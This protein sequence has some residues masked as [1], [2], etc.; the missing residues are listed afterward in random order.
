[1][2]HKKNSNIRLAIIILVLV[3]LMS[4]IVSAATVE[5]TTGKLPVQLHEGDQVDLTI[6]IKD[7]E[8][9]K[10]LVIETSLVS[11]NN[12][13]IYDFG[14]YNPSIA[15]NRFNQKITL[16]ISALPP[17]TFHVSISGKVPEGET[18]IKS[19]KTDIVISKFSETKLKFYEVLTDQKLAGIESFELV[20]AKKEKF[21]NTIGKITW[22]ELDGAK[23]EIRKLFDSGLTTE[24]QNIADELNKIKIPNSLS[25]FGLVKIENDIMLNSVAAV[26]FL[27]ALVIGYI[28]GARNPN[29]EN[30]NEDDENG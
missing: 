6:K 30:E 9:V 15:D 20:I 22:G 28:R 29:S 21:E 1:M 24:A 5:V 11:T 13:P 10:N 26:I 3:I 2:N 19:D 27:I 23:R 4:N 8:D 14:D 25:L 7:Y 18:R 17:N 12:K 16:D